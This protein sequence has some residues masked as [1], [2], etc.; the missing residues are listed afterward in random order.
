MNEPT[1]NEPAKTTGPGTPQTSGGFDLNQPTIISLCFLAGWGTGGVSGIVGLV[2]AMTW[3]KENREPWAD[4]HFTYHARTFWFALA[5]G[6]IGL[7]L[8]IAFIG[9]FILMLVPIYVTVRAIMS[10]LKAQKQEP[11]PEPETLLF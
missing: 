9:I 6:V 4:S 5:A 10:L 1:Q 2:L 7:V 11:M 3:Q 8:T